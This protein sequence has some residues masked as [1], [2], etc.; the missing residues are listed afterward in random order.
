TP[1]HYAFFS[2]N[3]ERSTSESVFVARLTCGF[4]IVVLIVKVSITYSDL[5]IVGIVDS[6]VSEFKIN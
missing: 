3:C 1:N 2:P 6:K 4:I 5:C